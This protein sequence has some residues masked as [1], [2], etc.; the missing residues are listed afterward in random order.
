[1]ESSLAS[2]LSQACEGVYKSVSNRLYDLNKRI[3][4]AQKS[5][6]LC[7]QKMVAKQRHLYSADAKELVEEKSGRFYLQSS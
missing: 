5:I 2:D 6:T 3:G 1:M 4:T 7:E